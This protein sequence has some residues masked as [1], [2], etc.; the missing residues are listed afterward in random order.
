MYRAIDDLA[1]SIRCGAHDDDMLSPKHQEAITV[2]SRYVHGCGVACHVSALTPSSNMNRIEEDL[3]SILQ[4]RKSRF[5]RFFSAKRH[6]SE[7]QDIVKQLER[8]DTNYMV[9]YAAAHYALTVL[10][11]SVRSGWWPP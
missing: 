5:K 1:T 6:R 7:L 8:A 9:R 11:R 3:A 10:T 4:E 2:L